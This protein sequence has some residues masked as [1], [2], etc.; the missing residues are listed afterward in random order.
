MRA[1]DIKILWGRSANRCAICKIE[2]TPDG[3]IE[4]IGEIAH[5][6]SRSPQGPR[7]DDAL[8]ST[9]RD[10]YSNLILLCPNHHSE[11]DKF[12]DS[13]PTEKLH[14]L[15]EEHEKWVSE[16]LQQGAISFKSIDNSSFLQAIRNSWVSFSKSKIWVVA[17]LTPLKVDDDSIDPLETN[18]VDT[19][20][21]LNL[22]D[23]RYW[24]AHL[25][26]YDTRPDENGITNIK[27]KKLEEGDGHKISIYRNGH[28][29]FL[30]CLEGSVNDM[31]ENAKYKEPDIIGSSRVIRY[32]H[33]AIVI[34][35]QIEALQKIWINCLQ[36]K[37]MTL[38]IHIIN[39][40]DCMLYS[41]K[42]DPRGALYGYPVQTDNL[43]YSFIVDKNSQLDNL[44]EIILKRFVNYFGLVLHEIFDNKRKFVRPEKLQI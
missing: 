36:F 15:K 43:D 20:N 6:I 3:E 8:L 18:V 37:N 33:L 12:P 25:N 7:G 39:T 41:R 21:S 34:A 23:D 22:P 9:E 17:S 26:A 13:W 16:Q 19:L 28:C 4:T 31:T 30:F 29:E 32:T 14:Q 40:R 5:I 42:K 11:I 2:L 27:L 1:K 35:K 24:N 10:D 38:T 44:I